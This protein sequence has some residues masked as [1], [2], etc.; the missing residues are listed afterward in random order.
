MNKLNVAILFGGC[1][2]EHEISKES[3]DTIISNI[4]H[5]KYNVIPIYISKDGKWF[6]YD[7]NIH[8]IKNIDFEKLGTPTIISTDR[9]RKGLIRI[10]GEKFKHLKV[11]VFFPVLHGKNGEDGVLQGVF[12]TSGIPYVGCGVLS[13]AVAMDKVFAKMIVNNID[14]LQAPFLFF[15]K[16]DLENTEQIVKE[17]RN[18]IGYPCFVKPASSGSS[19][20]ISKAKNKKQLLEALNTAI[21]YDN[22]VIVEKFIKGRE[23]ECAV[24]GTG[25]LDTKASL[26][27]EI[28]T[29]EEFYSFDAKY[30]NMESR[31]II[32]AQIS[33]EISKQIQ[34]SSL[35]I[36][37]LLDGKG[38]SRIDFFLEDSTNKVI[39]NE[40]NTFPGFTGIS[41]YP[42]LCKSMGYDIEALIDKL[43]EIAIYR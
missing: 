36:F 25:G 21:T 15:K 28:D 32:P 39:F 40:I 24:L 26:V 41:M 42:M 1:S 19:I 7:G 10:V 14:V 31:N 34:E 30:N 27:G 18:T 5:T 13:S 23:L 17:V 37:K 3:A 22:K 29:N 35:K 9:S 33:E 16:E 43:I 6:L 12:E 38:L 20:G 4:S 2:S 8:N 11:D